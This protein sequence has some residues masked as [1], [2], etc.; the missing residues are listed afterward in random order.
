MC[1]F[2]INN[3][4]RD[5][6]LHMECFARVTLCLFWVFFFFSDKI[7]GHVK[8]ITVNF[9]RT[10]K[11]RERVHVQLYYWNSSFQK[12]TLFF[13]SCFCCLFFL[14]FYSSFNLL[15]NSEQQKVFSVTELRSLVGMGMLC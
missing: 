6:F 2:E 14:H 15:F 13:N 5:D 9:E 4:K 11:E 7:L 12:I 3:Q 1:I 10:L 8:Q